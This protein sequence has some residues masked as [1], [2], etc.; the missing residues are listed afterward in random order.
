MKAR[1]RLLKGETDRFIMT[2]PK[3]IG[4]QIRENAAKKKLS[5]SAYLGFIVE[6]YLNKQQE[7]D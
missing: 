6:D 5:L 2:V 7:E 1:Q 4:D 3:E